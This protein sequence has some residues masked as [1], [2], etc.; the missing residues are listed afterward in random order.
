MPQA[1]P[2]QPQPGSTVSRLREAADSRPLRSRDDLS[3]GGGAAY[4]AAYGGGGGGR[5][6]D[7]DDDRGGGGLGRA[8]LDSALSG[9]GQGQRGGR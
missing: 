3:G 5:W 8:A 7:R 1:P 6:G 4:G 9:S 2:L